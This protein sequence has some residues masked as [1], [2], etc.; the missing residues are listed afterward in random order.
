MKEKAICIRVIRVKEISG[1]IWVKHQHCD[2]LEARGV[3]GWGWVG[4][5]C[6][7]FFFF[8]FFLGGGGGSCVSLP[9]N[10]KVRFHTCCASF[11]RASALVTTCP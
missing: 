8:F 7:F 1:H 2:L 3:G 6:F 5:G 10:I 9:G 11:N 4:L